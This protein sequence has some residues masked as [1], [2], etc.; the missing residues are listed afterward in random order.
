[1]SQEISGNR[2][3]WNHVG[4]ES[5]PVPEI[6]SIFELYGSDESNMLKLINVE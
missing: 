2:N 1:M 6:S 5:K 3:I 4:N